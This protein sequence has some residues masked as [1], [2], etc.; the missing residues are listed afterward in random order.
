MCPAS[1]PWLQLYPIPTLQYSEFITICQTVESCQCTD[2]I[3]APRSRGL[4]SPCPLRRFKSRSH[5]FPK[6]PH[7]CRYPQSPC[8]LPFL[9]HQKA[10]LSPPLD[11]TLTQP[12][13]HLY[14]PPSM[15]VAGSFFCSRCFSLE[16]IKSME[17]CLEPRWLLLSALAVCQDLATC[18]EEVLLTSKFLPLHYLT[19]P[20]P[21]NADTH[22]QWTRIVTVLIHCDLS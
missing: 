3:P 9:H 6:H 15:A 17:E 14:N 20:L 22:K 19:A 21:P 12:L 7:S 8:S 13:C 4:R 16:K 18:L 1:P 11:Q 10:H 5:S 2:M